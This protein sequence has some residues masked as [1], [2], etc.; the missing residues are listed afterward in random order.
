MAAGGRSGVSQQSV[1]S[2]TCGNVAGQSVI[3]KGR[4]RR[5]ISLCTENRHRARFIAGPEMTGSLAIA[6]P[7]FA[8]AQEPLR[9]FHT[10]VV[11]WQLWLLRVSTH[12]R[13]G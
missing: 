3:Y 10:R 5:E 4:G 1:G 2:Q 11:V 7:R 8:T 6:S 13:L 9:S 12:S